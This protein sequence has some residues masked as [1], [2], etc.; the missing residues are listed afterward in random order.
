[1]L[2]V[3]KI[4]RDDVDAERGDRAGEAGDE[5]AVLARARAMREHQRRAGAVA[6]NGIHERRGDGV[7]RYVDAKLTRIFQERPGPRHPS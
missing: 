4:E 5:R 2:G 7:R 1:M 3:E 6:P